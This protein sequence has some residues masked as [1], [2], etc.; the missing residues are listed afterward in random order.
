MS[1][2][3][4]ESQEEMKHRQH[5]SNSLTLVEEEEDGHEPLTIAAAEAA[6]KN[7]QR[8]GPRTPAPK[9]KAP[10]IPVRLNPPGTNASMTNVKLEMDYDQLMEYFDSLKETEA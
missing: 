5:P 10:P 7:H 1:F 6:R 2:I 9:C 3:D 8:K 4:E